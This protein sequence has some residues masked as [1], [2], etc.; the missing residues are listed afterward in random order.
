MRFFYKVKEKNLRIR[1]HKTL[2]I[3]FGVTRWLNGLKY[4]LCKHEP[5]N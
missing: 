4:L 5:L 2:I 1:E 3:I